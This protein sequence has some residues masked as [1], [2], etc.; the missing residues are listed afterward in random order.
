MPRIDDPQAAQTALRKA[1]EEAGCTVRSITPIQPS[2]EDAFI[3]LIEKQSRTETDRFEPA[4]GR[5]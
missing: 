3:A 1:M 5:P 2:L 4:G